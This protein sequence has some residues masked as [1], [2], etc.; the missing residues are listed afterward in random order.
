MAAVRTPSGGSHLYYEGDAQGNAS[1]SKHGLDLRGRGGYVLAPP[2]AVDGRSYVLV[3]RSVQPAQI[4]F[5]RIREHLQPQPQ[6]PV[7]SPERGAGRGVGHLPSWVAGLQEGN[8][9]AGLFWAA[10]RAVEAGDAH[11][12]DALA[13]A[14]ASTGLA[15]AAI[16]KTIASAQRTASPKAMDREAG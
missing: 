8:R 10:C 5:G 14:A 4:D 2:S 3:G 11:T 6:R 13:Q 15:Q 1:M 12:L 16:D 7:W 9:N